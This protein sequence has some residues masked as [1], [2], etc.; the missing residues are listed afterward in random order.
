MHNLGL[1]RPRVR[2]DKLPRRA[3]RALDARQQKRYLRAAERRPLAR[4]RA[5]G[6]LLFYS[7]LRVSELVALDEDDVPLSARRGKVIVRV[8]KN[9]YSREVPLVEPSARTAITEWKTERRSWRGADKTPALFI[10]RRGGRLSTRAAAQLVDELAIDADLVDDAGKPAASAHTLRHTFG[11]NLVRAGTDRVVVADL[12]GHHSL[13]TTRA[14]TLPTEED[15]EAA[16]AR[17]PADQ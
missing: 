8:G 12:M 2:R 1:D 3:P 6:R 11:T 17:L 4:D 16:V 5:I 7:G 10:N 13:E 9:G 14:Y 15:V